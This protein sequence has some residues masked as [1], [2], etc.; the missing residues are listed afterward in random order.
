MKKLQT[1]EKYLPLKLQHYFFLSKIQQDKTSTL[2]NYFSNQRHEQI[3][4]VLHEV[5]FEAENCFIEFNIVVKIC[6]FW[7]YIQSYTEAPP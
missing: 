3:L 5:L 7:K 4:L 6:L 2:F 1:P